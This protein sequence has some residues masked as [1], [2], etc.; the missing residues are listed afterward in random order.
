[1]F[2]FLQSKYLGLRLLGH[3]VKSVFTLLGKHVFQMRCSI[4]LA[5]QHQ[6]YKR[7]LV[8]P[9]SHQLEVLSLKNQISHFSK[10]GAI[11]H[12]G[13]NLNFPNDVEY[14][15]YGYLANTS[16]LCSVCMYSVFWPFV[17][18]LF[19]ISIIKFGEVFIYF[20]M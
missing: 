15:L 20:W 14:M 17:I 6:V 2:L 5:Y 18:F 1:M 16:L 13:F 19:F 12:C 3:M 9:Y 4:L 10:C 8:A 7:V 11:S